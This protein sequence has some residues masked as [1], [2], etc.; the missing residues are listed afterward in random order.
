MRTRYP[1]DRSFGIFSRVSPPFGRGI[2][3]LARAALSLVK[4]GSR[5]VSVRRVTIAGKVPVRA[6]LISI[7]M[8]AGLCSKRQDITTGTPGHMRRR[9]AACSSL[10]TASRRTIPVLRP[11]RT[12][13]RRMRGRRSMPQSLPSTPRALR[14]A[15]T[16]RAAVWRRTSAFF[17]RPIWRRRSMTVCTMKA[18]PLRKNCAD[19]MCP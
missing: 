6:F 16:R 15:G 18:S 17:R 8:A 19:S 13:L 1:I 3:A 7:F 14:W 9:G 5:G 2:F 10:T 11:T 4:K 12:V